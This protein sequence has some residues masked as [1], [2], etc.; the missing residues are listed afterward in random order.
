LVALAGNVLEQLL[1]KIDVSENHT[2]AAVALETDGVEGITRKVGVLAGLVLSQKSG[3]FHAQLVA[4]KCHMG[5]LPFLDF[6]GE[7]LHVLLPQI[8]DDLCDC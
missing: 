3:R 8:A 4:H 1:D 5:N 6:L 2:T 7:E